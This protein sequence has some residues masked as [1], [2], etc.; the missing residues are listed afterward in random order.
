MTDTDTETQCRLPMLRDLTSLELTPQ[1]RVALLV[2]IFQ[3]T[4]GGFRTADIA[5]AFGL[6]RRGTRSLLNR[7]S[8]AV[9]LV[10]E[11]GHWKMLK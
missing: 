2:Y 1:G 3:T 11:N 6:T 7:I 8:G 4:N 9:P 5:A 10:R